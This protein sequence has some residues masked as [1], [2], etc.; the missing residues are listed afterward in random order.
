[1]FDVIVRDAKVVPGQGH[2]HYI[3][4]LGI[5]FTVQ[6]DR[7]PVE[8]GGRIDDFG[9]LCVTSGKTEYVG[10]NLLWTPGRIVCLPALT[11]RN[12]P[13]T[14]HAA[15]LL[16]QGVTTVIGILDLDDESEIN[17]L[18]AL[19]GN[20][21]L[22]INIGFVASCQNTSTSSAADRLV[23]AISLGV[24]GLV[25]NE[26]SKLQ[27]ILD[28]FKLPLLQELDL[29]RSEKMP[30]SLTDLT[31]QIHSAAKLLGLGSRGIIKLGTPA[32]LLAFTNTV[33]TPLSP[34]ALQRVMLGGRVVFENGQASSELSGTL[35][36]R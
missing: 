12:L 17:A 21:P 8:R 24:F 22:P 29:S 20:S 2:E 33:A 5:N 18:A 32:D 26:A 4:D 25:A 31:E 28:W 7:V 11:P 27:T 35:L 15:E 1:L 6:E 23:Q 3:A 19:D 34:R 10:E 9:D 14:E 30:G 13:T 36:R 16:A